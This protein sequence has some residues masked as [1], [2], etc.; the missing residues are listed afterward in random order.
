MNL[1]ESNGK[2]SMPTKL[3]ETVRL[4]LWE[5]FRRDPNMIIEEFDFY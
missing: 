2:T 5:A 4:S 3:Y 1:E